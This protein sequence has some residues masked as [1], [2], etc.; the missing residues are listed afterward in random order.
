MAIVIDSFLSKLKKEYNG[1][2]LSLKVYFYK[3]IGESIFNGENIFGIDIACDNEDIKKFLLK[4]L[5]DLYNAIFGCMK[6]NNSDINYEKLTRKISDIFKL[7]TDDDSA[8][9]FKFVKELYSIYNRPEYTD[10]IDLF[11][12]SVLNKI[13]SKQANNFDISFEEE[14]EFKNYIYYCVSLELEIEENRINIIPQIM[15]SCRYLINKSKDSKNVSFYFST[16]IL[17][18][19][20]YGI[21]D[22][23]NR[24]IYDVFLAELLLVIVSLFKEKKLDELSIIFNNIKI[25]DKEKNIDSNLLFCL[26]VVKIISVYY[27]KDKNFI[28]E[29]QEKIENIINIMLKNII[30]L[31]K[32]IY[33]FNYVRYIVRNEREY[34]KI[35]STIRSIEFNILKDDYSN[36]WAG[37]CCD[38]KEMSMLLFAIL[39]K[40]I[41][42]EFILTKENITIDMNNV[43]NC[44]NSSS[45]DEKYKV[46][47]SIDKDDFDCIKEDLITP[48]IN[49][50]KEKVSE[51]INKNDISNRISL[52]EE[53]IQKKLDI[54]EIVPFN[55]LEY[56]EDIIDKP[57]IITDNIDI[58]YFY[59]LNNNYQRILD[60][61]LC[62]FEK[63]IH[64]MIRDKINE[65]ILETY[66]LLDSF[67]NG[68]ETVEEYYIFTSIYNKKYVDGYTY[69]GKKI[70]KVYLNYYDYFDC[71]FCYIV[72][73][74]NIPIV[75]FG[76]ADIDDIFR[77][78]KYIKVSENFDG[79][80]INILCEFIM[81]VDIKKEKEYYRARIIN[82]I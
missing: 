28:I 20:F 45:F 33:F 65:N 32:K 59:N 5:Y 7:I 11:N 71:E 68:I 38:E 53:Q 75:H 40:N 12:Y 24:K 17:N 77:Y 63:I 6:I 30:K 3:N 22:K 82:I 72:K 50:C 76:R 57:I 21:K 54:N 35:I 8:F 55:V 23:N 47:F 4:N 78:Y 81:R 52:F 9:T 66:D 74:D 61:Y 14:A 69:N 39:K 73:D 56:S 25:Y 67:F 60:N 10:I 44:F 70:K 49:V 1:K 37:F 79:D 41:D 58:L 13:L 18:N 27:D 16:K 31:N 62:F 2:T 42:I 36:S 34:S 26:G 29:N 46:I 80:K 43:L 15:S 51:T 48:C 64:G 19:L